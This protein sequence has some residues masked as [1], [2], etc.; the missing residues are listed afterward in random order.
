M[1]LLMMYIRCCRSPWMA[2][3]FPER[4]Q[5][6]HGDGTLNGTRGRVD[7]V[8]PSS[9]APVEPRPGEEGGLFGDASQGDTVLMSTLFT[10]PALIAPSQLSLDGKKVTPCKALLRW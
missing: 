10:S 8:L 3:S 9:Q 2:I 7:K 5:P 6:W 1:F 4:L